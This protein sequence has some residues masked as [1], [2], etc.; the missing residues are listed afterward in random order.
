MGTGVSA[1]AMRG[2]PL[3]VTFTLLRVGI[4]LTVRGQD[5]TSSK[6]CADLAAIAGDNSW[7]TAMGGA[8]VCG[9]SDQGLGMGSS[10]TC[11]GQLGTASIGFSQA[12]SICSDA[13]AR[14]CTVEELEADE[15][16]G[17][18]CN[19]DSMFVW[20]STDIG[21]QDG[22][23]LAVMGSS[24]FADGTQIC[25]E[26]GASAAVRCC[27][28]VEVGVPCGSD[29][30]APEPAIFCGGFSGAL[31]PVGQRC[32]SPPNCPDCGGTCQ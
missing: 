25:V 27:A 30:P 1:G 22:Q 15:T 21:C 8:A 4:L 11:Y 20:S 13:G 16:R 10:S 5:C 19:H 32:I 12:N 28:D 29:A 14:L 6:S 2:A 7:P 3:L 9:E 18:G 23:H 26:N 17:T 31:C 24:A